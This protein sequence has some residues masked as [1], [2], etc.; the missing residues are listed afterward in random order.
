MWIF[1]IHRNYF[2]FDIRV[3][4]FVDYQIIT[5]IQPFCS[6]TE[7][8][9]KAGANDRALFVN[10]E[11]IHC[12]TS[13]KVFF[14]VRMLQHDSHPLDGSVVNAWGEEFFFHLVATVYAL[15]C[16]VCLSVWQ[17]DYLFNCSI[18]ALKYQIYYCK[19]AMQLLKPTIE[20]V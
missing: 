20:N 15:I 17:S 19:A 7:I 12:T 6:A 10:A 18:K 1:F 8:L 16:C 13:G 14:A 5:I 2:I 9:R 4:I 3:T 11:L